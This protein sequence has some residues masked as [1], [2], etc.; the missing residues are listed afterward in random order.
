MPPRDTRPAPRRN[1]L[2]R[3]YAKSGYGRAV[4]QCYRSASRIGAL[5]YLESVKEARGT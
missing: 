5:L 3:V 2:P 4:G 1:C